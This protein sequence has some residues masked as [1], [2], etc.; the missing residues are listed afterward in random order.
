MQ[1]VLVVD[2]KCAPIVACGVTQRYKPFSCVYSS[3]PEKV[4]Q[5]GP[6]FSD[7]FMQQD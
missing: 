4:P 3:E 1:T 7:T 5:Y 6:I 2:L